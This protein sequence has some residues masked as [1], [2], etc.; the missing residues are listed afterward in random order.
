M[1]W[2]SRAGPEPVLAEAVAVAPTA[3][4]VRGRHPQILDQ[5]LGVAGGA[6]HGLD[7]AHLRP[8][9]GR[10]VD[11]ERRVGRLREIGVVLGAGDEDG[12]ARPVGVGDEPLVAVDDP[13]VA[14]LD[15]VG[16]D[17]GRVRS[18]DL[19]LGHGEARPRSPL[20][21]AAQIALL[22]L[23]RAPVQEGVHV[24]FVGS[25]AVEHPGAQAG[26]GRLRLHH[27]QLDVTETHPAPLRRHVR[28]PQ[29]LGEGLLA[30][31][32]Q[33]GA[34]G[35]TVGGLELL[36]LDPLLD[37]PHHVVDEGPDPVPQLLELRSEAEVDAH[38]RR[39]FHRRSPRVLPPETGRAF[40]QPA[41]KTSATPWYSC[42]STV[43]SVPTAS[44]SGTRTIWPA[45]SATI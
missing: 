19:G 1:Q 25:L 22:L 34:V 39:V 6:V 36:G 33:L 26:P 20:A 4:Q 29:P 15:G 16:A 28:Q 11:E 2:A 12:E 30:Q 27:G 32:S 35:L 17:Q 8:P 31:A 40:R 3:E 37:R 45:C 10:D 43:L 14:V 5:D 24:A 9:L 23:V 42:G 18:G 38:A 21:Q 7:L 13:L 44:V 41:K